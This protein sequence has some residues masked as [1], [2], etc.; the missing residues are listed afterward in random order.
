MAQKKDS[1]IRRLRVMLSDFRKRSY[2]WN[3][4]NGGHSLSLSLYFKE[5]GGLVVYIDT[6]LYMNNS[7]RGMDLYT[8]IN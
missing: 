8:E 5:E 3:V 1:L 2:S 7:T 4:K 6:P